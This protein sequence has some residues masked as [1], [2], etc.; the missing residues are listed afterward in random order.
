MSLRAES[1]A[2]CFVRENGLLEPESQ[3]RNY[4]PGPVPAFSRPTCHLRLS[5]L[6]IAWLLKAP[7][8]RVVFIFSP[9]ES[10]RLLPALV[11]PYS[12]GS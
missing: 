10:I 9:A 11:P 8:V 12:D 1:R 2:L 4:R 7:T 5:A 3:R 6:K